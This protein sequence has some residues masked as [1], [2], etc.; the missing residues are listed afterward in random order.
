MFITVCD[1]CLCLCIELAASNTRVDVTETI[2]TQG[3][4]VTLDETSIFIPGGALPIETKVNL[5]NLSKTEIHQSLQ[6]SQ[7]ASMVN[8][9]TAFNIGCSPPITQFN[10]PIV[11][12]VTLPY[13]THSPK[14]QPFRL[15]QSKYRNNWSDITDEPDTQIR[16]DNNKL[17]VRTNHTGW[18]LVATINIDL[19][20]IL[21]IAV[22]S[23][24][25]EE[26]ITLQVNV[27]GRSLSTNSAEITTFITPSTKED[28]VLNQK[29]DPPTSDHKRVSFP[30]SFKAYK[31][32]KLQ[33]EV[34][35]AFN[36][37]GIIG[38][39]HMVDN[40]LEAVMTKDISFL[41]SS[42][43]IPSNGKLLVSK[44]CNVH[45]KWELVQEIR[46]T[47]SSLSDTN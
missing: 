44:Y 20:Q 14:H 3:G 29:K 10:M 33:L 6:T 39:E 23:V 13:D 47:L 4:M 18:L 2:T 5:S 24:F 9:I 34:Q 12:S 26:P 40:Q 1:I 22:K 46:L 27:F 25:A 31:G 45:K 7:W 15:L 28:S 43:S 35:G 30:H 38:I 21:Q 19:S 17:T 16:L 41:A 42:S 11:A 32:Q 8:I 36:E 37:Q